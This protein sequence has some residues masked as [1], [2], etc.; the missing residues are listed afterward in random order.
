MVEPVSLNQVHFQTS[1]IPPDVVGTLVSA[2]MCPDKSGKTR[3]GEL[4]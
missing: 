4:E 2:T 1:V 3:R